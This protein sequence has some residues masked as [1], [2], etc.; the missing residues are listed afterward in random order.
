MEADQEQAPA[1]AEAVAAA[2]SG[3]FAEV[4]IPVD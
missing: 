3:S 4:D 2:T 1:I